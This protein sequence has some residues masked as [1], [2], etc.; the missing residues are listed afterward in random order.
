MI[1]FRAAPSLAE[2]ANFRDG[3]ESN[4]WLLE[5]LTLDSGLD[6][7][8]VDDAVRE[9]RTSSSCHSSLLFRFGRKN[10]AKYAVEDFPNLA[11]AFVTSCDKKR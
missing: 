5:R 1:E 8:G 7:H 2:N 11:V 9:V 3:T 4:P 10:F 6:G